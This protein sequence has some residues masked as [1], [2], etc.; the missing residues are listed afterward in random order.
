M[1]TQWADNVK[2]RILSGPQENEYRPRGTRKRFRSQEVLARLRLH[3]SYV[4]V[5]TAGPAHERLFTCAAMIGG[6]Q[7]GIGRGEI[8]HALLLMTGPGR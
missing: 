2:A 5:D 6:E 3:V 4:V 1:D 8:A 7:L